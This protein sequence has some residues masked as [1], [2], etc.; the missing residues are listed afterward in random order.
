MLKF[1]HSEPDSRHYIYSWVPC[2]PVS[3]VLPLNVAL[4]VIKQ[5]TEKIIYLKTIGMGGL[6]LIGMASNEEEDFLQGY[7]GGQGV[8]PSLEVPPCEDHKE[9]DCPGK[10]IDVTKSC[11]YFELL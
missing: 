7:S 11:R 3:N 9:E 6:G 1:H 8:D 5:E 10:I 4:L 2:A